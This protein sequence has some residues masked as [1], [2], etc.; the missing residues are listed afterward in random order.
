MET[1]DRFFKHKKA[2]QKAKIDQESNLNLAATQLFNCL[3]AK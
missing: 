3:C 2:Q 1:L